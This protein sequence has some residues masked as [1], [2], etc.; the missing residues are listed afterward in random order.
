MEIGLVGLV[1]NKRGRGSR[2]IL[3][4]REVFLRALRSVSL[5][6]FLSSEGLM[7]FHG[8]ASKLFP[9]YLKNWGFG[10]MGGGEGVVWEDSQ[11]FEGIGLR[12]HQTF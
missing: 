3:K 8:V 12:N 5:W 4:G 11:A 1:C 6:D 10:I 9:M 7:R 2:G